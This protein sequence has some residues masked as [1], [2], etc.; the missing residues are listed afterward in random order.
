MAFPLKDLIRGQEVKKSK[1]S[2]WSQQNPYKH[3]A[4]GRQE[5][6]K[7]NSWLRVINLPTEEHNCQ[8]IPMVIYHL[9]V[10]AEAQHHLDV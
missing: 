7:M 5:R 1:S 3:H 2:G 8:C 4:A 10:V 9:I 6:I